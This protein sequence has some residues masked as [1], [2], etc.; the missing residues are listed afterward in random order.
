MALKGSIPWNKGLSK[1]TDDRLI[2]ISEKVSRTLKMKGIRPP[3]RKG[4][5][6]SDEAKLRL[7]GRI[8]W[9]QGLTKATDG[10]LKRKGNASR[11]PVN[12]DLLRKLYLV[13]KLSCIDIAMKMGIGRDTILARVQ[14]L[15][16][17]R[18]LSESHKGKILSVVSK[19]RL[20]DSLKLAYKTGKKVSWNTKQKVKLS[21]KECGKEFSVR[22]FRAKAK[23][24]SIKCRGKWKTKQDNTKI[25]FV[26]NHCGKKFFIYPCEKNKRIACSIRCSKKLHWQNPGF[27]AKQMKARNVYPNKTELNLEKFLSKVFPNEYKYVGDGQ[28]ILAGKCPD[29]VNVNGQKKIIELYGDYWHKGQNPQD[30]IDLFAKF[31]WGT[32][33]IWEKEMKNETLLKEKLLNFNLN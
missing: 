17:V 33:I 22:P 20:S 13:D 11:I 5:K 28:F 29:F 2:Q 21:C 10:R 3:S 16:I 31:G 26:C 18:N 8:P 19:K 15:G 32:L 14:E 30:R 12:I 4:I 1:K 7:K 9:C 23:F 27:V 25:N 6:L 24:C